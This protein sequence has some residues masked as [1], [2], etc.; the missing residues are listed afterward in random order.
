[1]SKYADIR[2]DV[3]RRLENGESYSSIGKHYGIHR[4]QIRRIHLGKAES[5]YV[6][7]DG[8]PKE[9]MARHGLDPECWHA[10]K[11]K[12]WEAQTKNGIQ[13]LCSTE[14]RR[15]DPVIEAFK[16]IKWKTIPRKP[17]KT[18]PATKCMLVIPDSQCG[19]HRKL[20]GTLVPFHNRAVLDACLKAAKMLAPRLDTILFQ[21]DML[22]LNQSTRR[23]TRPESFAAT[24]WPALLEWRWLLEKFRECGKHSKLIHLA[25]NHEDRLNRIMHDFA[26]EWAWIP[27]VDD[28]D[29]PPMLSLERILGYKSIDVE[30]KGPYGSVKGEHWQWGVRFDHGD[31]VGAKSGTTVSKMANGR[32]S[33]CVGHV[34]R[35][36]LCWTRAVERDGVERDCFYLTPGC[37]SHIDGDRVPSAAARLN[38]ANGFAVLWLSPDGWVE[39]TLVR[40]RPDGRCML[41]GVEIQGEDYTKDLR[42]QT[43]Y[44]F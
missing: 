41:N 31:K 12:D 30:F 10:V 6:E 36:E 11:V 18:E 35:A 44:P 33:R 26:P 16:D 3:L 5:E 9:V 37:T 15:K 28:P 23:F 17:F 25:G 39:P 21:G 4:N 42:E 7:G 20:D 2:D 27:P 38:W 14:L 19:F 40:V 32:T 13:N 29:G 1:M 8:T 22:D 24:T 34:H 43:G